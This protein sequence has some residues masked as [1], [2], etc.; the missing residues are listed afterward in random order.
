MF[1]KILVP[2]DGSPAAL[3]AAETIAARL[4]PGSNL[5]VT[6]IVAIAPMDWNLTDFDTEFVVEQ[7]RQMHTNAERVLAKTRDIFA[8][9]GIAYTAKILEGNP[10]SAAIACEAD[11]GGYDLIVMSS[12][13]MGRQADSLHYMGSVTEHVIR[14][15]STPV[16]VI[17]PPEE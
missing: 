10:V 3:H 5:Q 13:G 14:R 9:H 12:R 15:V 4:K 7:N 17:P 2:T 16:L 8:R 1:K 11:T 6:I